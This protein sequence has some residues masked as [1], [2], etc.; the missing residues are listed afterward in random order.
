MIIIIKD[1]YTE[2]D[3]VFPLL[4]PAKSWLQT[5]EMTLNK[6]KM[7]VLKVARRRPT[8]LQPQD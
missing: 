7:K 3:D 2:K 5:P 6:S 8:G 1:V 4:Y